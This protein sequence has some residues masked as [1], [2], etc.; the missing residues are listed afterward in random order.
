MSDPEN[1]AERIGNENATA[2]NVTPATIPLLRLNKLSK[3]T[4]VVAPRP[5]VTG[6]PARPAHF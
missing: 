2:A 1:E 5:K 4:K 3:T 6:T